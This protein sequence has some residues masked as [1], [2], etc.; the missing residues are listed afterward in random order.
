MARET[1]SLDMLRERI[2]DKYAPV[3]YRLADGTLVELT[4]PLRLSKEQR[5]ELRRLAKVN[6]DAVAADR[7]DAE[8]RK[9]ANEVRAKAGQPPLEESDEDREAREDA[10]TARTLN[11]FQGII[12]LAATDKGLA[13]RML[14]EIESVGDDNEQLLILTEF[15]RDYMDSTQMGEASP[16]AS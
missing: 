11:Y 3:E 2:H 10:A 8:D 1:F 5:A 16:S 14:A 6:A 12:T 7:K 13:G 9:T 4:L 15:V